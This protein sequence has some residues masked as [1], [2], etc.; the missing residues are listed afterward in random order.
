MRTFTLLF[1]AFLLGTTVQAQTVATFDDLSL[2]TT[3]TYYVNYSAFGTDVGFNDGL[4]YFPCIYDTSGGFTFWNYF[5]YSNETD[6]VTSGYSNQYSAKTGVGYDGSAEY[7]VAYCSNPVTYANTMN[8]NLRGAAVGHPV[9]G[10]YITNS[11]YVYNTIAPGYPVEY[12]ARKFHN[13]DWFK[14][15]IYG[16][17]GG[18]LKPDSATVYLADFLFPDTTM[19]Y[20]LNTW[21]WVDLLPLGNVDSLQFALS[22]TDNGVYG[23]NTPAYF[24][25]DNFTT[26]ETD[27]AVDTTGSH[28]GANNIIPATVAKVYPNPATNT[29]C[30]DVTGNMVRQVS[31]MDMTGNLISTYGVT[32]DHMEINTATLAAGTYI[33]QLSGYGKTASMKFVKQ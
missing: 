6:S 3:D 33:L 21:Q 26:Y 28:L 30:L 5:V 18:V 23:M 17:S 10:F 25:M 8:L 4:G 2:P 14:L 9:K 11:T 1:S 12:P 13:G 15:T 31:V 32:T 22:S 24:C 27:T 7:L 16:Y 29:L 20:V 19:N